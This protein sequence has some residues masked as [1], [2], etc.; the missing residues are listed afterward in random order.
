MS[1]VFVLIYRP[2][3]VYEEVH[4]YLVIYEKAINHTVQYVYNFAPDPLVLT[5][6]ETHS[7]FFFY[8]CIAPNINLELL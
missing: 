7:F 3:P 1:V 4:K 6:E 5:Y 2:H 8:Q